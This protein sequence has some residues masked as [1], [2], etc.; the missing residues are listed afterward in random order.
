[1]LIEIRDQTELSKQ[2]AS[3]A[4]MPSLCAKLEKVYILIEFLKKNINTVFRSKSKCLNEAEKNQ[5]STLELNI[6]DSL[7]N[8]SSQSGDELLIGNTSITEQIKQV[9]QIIKESEIDQ[10]KQRI[11]E[12]EE[13]A[14][15]ERI[16]REQQQQ[17]Q[18]VKLQQAAENEAKLKKVEERKRVELEAEKLRAQ[19][20]EAQRKKL[21]RE[22]KQEQANLE[23]NKKM[24]NLI[25][26]L[27]KQRSKHLELNMDTMKD[28]FDLIRAQNK[29]IKNEIGHLSQRNQRRKVTR[30][31]N[32]FSF[33]YIRY[34]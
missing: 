3:N 27:T 23:Q 1:M 8:R 29:Q 17:Q 30:F 7:A 26:I 20:E 16:M 6:I 10:G 2:T 15:N 34:V 18:Q 25:E 12:L 22:S 11:R 5:L 21:A 14:E 28:Q 33:F 4:E 24:Q 13:Q 19:E 32:I 31:L 9:N